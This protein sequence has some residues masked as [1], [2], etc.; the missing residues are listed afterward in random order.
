MSTTEPSTLARA[1]AEGVRMS[2][3]GRGTFLAEVEEMMPEE[4][5]DPGIVLWDPAAAESKGLT[6]DGGDGFVDAPE[7][8]PSEVYSLLREGVE[9]ERYA[10]GVPFKDLLDRVVTIDYVKRGHFNQKPVWVFLFTREDGTTAHTTL[11][12]ERV[13]PATGKLRTPGR[14]A[15][16]LAMAGACSRPGDPLVLRA[17]RHPSSIAGGNGRFGWQAPGDTLP[18]SR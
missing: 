6:L 3:V 2:D 17:V 11:D 15:E 4:D 9:A 7:K 10:Q 18:S 12:R 5:S 8:T 14:D 13:D 16:A 1:E